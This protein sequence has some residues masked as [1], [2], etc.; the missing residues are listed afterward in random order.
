MCRAIP[1]VSL[2][3]GVG[4]EISRI[5]I[6]SNQGVWDLHLVLAQIM[7][8]PLEGLAPEKAKKTIHMIWTKC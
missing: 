4:I 1:R 7:V 5:P 3:C 2:G 8:A 6:F